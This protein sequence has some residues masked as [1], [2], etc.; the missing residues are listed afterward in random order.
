M[1]TDIDIAR[2]AEPKTIDVIATKLGISDEYLERYGKFKGK[3]D[4]AIN[5]E[6]LKDT[7]NGKLILVTAISPTPAGEGKTTTSVGLV[8]GLCHIG[9]KAMICLRA[10]S[11]THLRAH[12]T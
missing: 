11:Y 6:Q 12:E 8:D 7:K 5:H 10:V 9:N 1:K 2:E 3:V 4:L